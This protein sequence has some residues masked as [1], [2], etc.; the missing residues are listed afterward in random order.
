[1]D[2]PFH[3]DNPVPCPFDAEGSPTFTKNLVEKGELK[4]LLYNLKTAAI[5]GKKTTGNASKAG[6]TSAVAVRPFTMCMAPGSY[7]EEE[8]L[9]RAG[10][11]V[12]IDALA[13]LHAGADAVTGDFSLQSAGYLIEN[14]KKGAHIKSFTVAGNF[15]DLLKNIE[16]TADNF[17]IP[18]ALSSTAFGSPSVLV[19]SLSIAGK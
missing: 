5:A 10:N 18:V 4:T 13:G 9:Q 11:G 16:A 14:G 12:Y 8:L 2:D 7:T 3:K 1:M 19:S 15:F 6:Y 17:E